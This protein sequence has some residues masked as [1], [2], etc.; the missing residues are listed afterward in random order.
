[1][2]RTLTMAAA[3]ALIAAPAFATAPDFLQP[4]FKNTIVSTYP[5]GRQAKLWLNPDGT[6]RATGRRGKPSS[7]R[8]TLKGEQICMKQQR[9][10]SAPMSYCTP[11]HRGGVGTTWTGKAVT[12]EPIRISVVAGR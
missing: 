1:M 11:V 8:W 4:A 2:I 9:P 6:Y 7:G 12:G 10:F 3:A 5:D